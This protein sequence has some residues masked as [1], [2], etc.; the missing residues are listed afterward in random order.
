MSGQD[1]VLTVIAAGGL[2]WIQRVPIHQPAW[3]F[4]FLFVL[5]GS[6]A[7]IRLYYGNI[8]TQTLQAS[9]NFQVA[10]RMFNDN[11]MLQRQLDN[12]LY[13]L[14]FLSTTCLVYLVEIRYRLFPY[15]ITGI[16]LYFFNLSLLAGLFFVRVIL[17]NLAGFLFNRIRIFREYLYNAFIFNKLIGVV[18]LPLLLFVVYTTGPVKEIFHWFTLG[19]VFVI[20]IMRIIRGVIFSFKKDVSIF[21]MILYLC[22]LELVPLALLYKWIEGIL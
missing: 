7:W 20:L 11:S 8:L 4:I 2:D 17:V 22:A 18:V 16:R 19:V 3:L 10:T 1:P 14:Y 5:L 15:G 13:L 21:Y 9:S 6:F 12:V